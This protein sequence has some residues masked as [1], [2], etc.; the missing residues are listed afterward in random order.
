[1][2]RKRDLVREYKERKQMRGVFAVRCAATG[3]AWVS[4]APNLD[5]QANG[6]WFQLRMGNHMNKPLQAAWNAHGESAFAY[7]ILAELPDEARSDYALKADLKALEEEWRAKLSA[8]KVF[9]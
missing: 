1:M 2:A 7:E 8:G 6:L 3:E 4:A 5:T 9:G